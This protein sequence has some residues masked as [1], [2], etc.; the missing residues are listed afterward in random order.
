[1]DLITVDK[2]A[3][4]MYLTTE[5]V[6]PVLSGTL[7]ITNVSS[8]AVSFKVK[9][10]NYG[11]Y[12][13]KPNIGT[14][15]IGQLETIKIYMKAPSTKS[16]TK[17]LSQD[18]FLL[19]A[20]SDAVSDQN[21]KEERQG[22]RSTCIKMPVILETLER[23]E[24]K[25]LIGCLENCPI[26]ID[27]RVLEMRMPCNTRDSLPRDTLRMMNNGLSAVTFRVLAVNERY[28]SVRPTSGVLKAGTSQTILFT[29]R[30]S[31]NTAP[32]RLLDKF[33][34]T[35]NGDFEADKD[36]SS[37]N[38]CERNLSVW[39][40]S[41]GVRF[42]ESQEVPERLSL[43]SSNSSRVISERENL[44]LCS[45][46]GNK[47]TSKLVSEG[48]SPSGIFKISTENKYVVNEKGG[49][50]DAIREDVLVT[51]ITEVLG[52]NDG[53]SVMPSD[54]Y[55]FLVEEKNN[56]LSQQL[57]MLEQLVEEHRRELG[58]LQEQ[59]NIYMVQQ[60]HSTCLPLPRRRWHLGWRKR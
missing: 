46:P 42:L 30:P 3:V 18:K 33:C 27:K 32:S 56:R 10:N 8:N 37:L 38:L 14:L 5:Q 11:R 57:Q 35:F 41:I 1:M 20:T 53:L 29:V 50:N 21:A 48:R 7:T 19:S 24:Q 49:P 43:R 59:V 16:L 58:Q 23:L 55:S 2:T 4:H 52:G 26:S 31:W 47:E 6:I 25:D 36:S 40:Y 39:S 9:T 13:V 12:V 28:Y 45:E 34:I 44:Q 22:G 51:G 54:P 17:E 15:A 60:S